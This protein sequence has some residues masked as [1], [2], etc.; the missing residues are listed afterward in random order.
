MNDFVYI[1]KIVN[2]HG[3]RG[4]LR[5][6]SEFSH[7]DKA[8]QI[9]RM[10]YIGRD[11][12]E[13]IITGYRKHKMFDM[14]TLKGYTN[15]NEVLKYK[16]ALCYVKRSDLELSQNEYLDD[17][18]VGLPVFID[19]VECGSVIRLEKVTEKSKVLWIFYEKREIAI[20]FVSDFVEVQISNRRIVIYPIEGLLS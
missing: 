15:I 18:L 9:G 8:F 20:P 17:D 4:E 5:L 1:G 6:L 7:K 3:I 19:G 10:I 2:T 14:I 16:G 12:V 13:E 11:K